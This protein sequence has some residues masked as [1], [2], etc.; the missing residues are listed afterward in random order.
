VA[1]PVGDELD[2]GEQDQTDQNNQAEDFGDFQ[3]DLPWKLGC[4]T[5]YTR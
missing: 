3:S 2:E 4:E 5:G 1:A